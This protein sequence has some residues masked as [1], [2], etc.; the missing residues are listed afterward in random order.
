MDLKEASQH[1][2]LSPRTLYRYLE[3]GQLKGQK[4]GAGPGAHW[5]I[6]QDSLANFLASRQGNGAQGKANGGQRSEQGD[7]TSNDQEHLRELVAVLKE[8]VAIK[9]RQ[10]EAREREV[11]ELHILLQQAQ[12]A[13]PP[14]VQHSLHRGWWRRLFS[15]KN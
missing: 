1:S 13:L 12:K 7:G 6:D 8:Q 5:E 9:D 11:Q 4:V 2:G 15:R 14:P 3:N 10:L